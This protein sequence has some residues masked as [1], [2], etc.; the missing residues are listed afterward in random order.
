MDKGYFKDAMIGMYEFDM[1]YIYFMPQHLLLHQW[2]ALSNPA[3][4]DFNEVTGYLKLS[5]SV[6]CTGDEQVQITEDT[7][8]GDDDKVMMPPQIRP[9]YYQ[10]KFRFFKAALFGKGG[11]IDAYLK[12]DYMN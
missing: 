5:I 1:A 6:A 3:S 7:S 4:P 8:T 2:V 9:E 12:C 10:L 11:S